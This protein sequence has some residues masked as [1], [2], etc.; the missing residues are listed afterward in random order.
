MTEADVGA[1][2][3]MI[4]MSR[5]LLKVQHDEDLERQRRHK[6]EAND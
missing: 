3:A 5:K 4:R 2:L 1:L 6:L